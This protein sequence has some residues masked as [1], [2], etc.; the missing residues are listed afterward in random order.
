[1]WDFYPLK[2]PRWPISEITKC[3]ESDRSTDQLCTSLTQLC[4]RLF[5]SGGI[6]PVFLLVCV[7]V[8]HVRDGAR[9]C[10]PSLSRSA[11]TF[12]LPATSRSSRRD[13]PPGRPAVSPNSV[14]P[15]SRFRI[16]PSLVGTSFAFSF[17][18]SSESPV[19]FG[20]HFSLPFRHLFF[21]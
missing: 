14:R 13:A 4:A 18:L 6:A 17:W 9:P 16:H 8:R 5:I 10:R 7:S 12:S 19:L 21:R 2:S 15:P 20:C 3:P 1:M 11:S